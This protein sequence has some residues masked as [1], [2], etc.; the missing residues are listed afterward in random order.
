MQ[1]ELIILDDSPESNQDIIDLH[2]KDNKIT[3][4]Y[5]KERII[6][7]K[8]RNMLNEMA[9]GDYIF[10]FDDDDYYPPEKIS[11]AITRM[12]GTKSIISGSSE[13]YIYY[14]HINKIY[15]TPFRGN[16]HATN[17]TY[18]YHKS[19]L[20]NHKCN[21]DAT[22][23]E[24]TSFTNNW[25]SPILQLDPRK[26]ILCISHDSNTYDKKTI[27]N[28][29]KETKLRLKDFIDDKKFLKLYTEKFITGKS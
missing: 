5:S 17:G 13:M 11:Y 3:Y 29:L 24:E 10:C 1:K 16:N 21:D 25:D 19:Y 23:A 2:K 18:A 27:I 12:T 4:V 26:T 9:K 8:K 15:S 28:N 20:K 6:L 14:T 22:F 7:G